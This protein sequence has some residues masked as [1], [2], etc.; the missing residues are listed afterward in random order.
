MNEQAI[1]EKSMLETYIF[2]LFYD[3]FMSLKIGCNP[4]IDFLTI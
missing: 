2:M 4:N 1:S 3:K